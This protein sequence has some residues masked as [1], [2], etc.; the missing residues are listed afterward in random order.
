MNFLSLP[1]ISLGLGALLLGAL[2]CLKSTKPRLAAVAGAT[3]SLAFF[4]L[5]AFDSSNACQT[6]LF[7]PW[8]PCFEAD[9]LDAVPMAFFAALTLAVLILAPKRDAWGRSL[10]GI[11][12]LVAATQTT[13][14]AEN[15]AVLAAGW[16]LTSLP[17]ALRMFGDDRSRKITLGALMAASLALTAGIISLHHTEIAEISHASRLSFGLM[18]LAI[19]L[20]KGLFPIHGWLIHSFEH[21]P[22]LPLAL[23]FNGHLGALLAARSETAALTLAEKDVLVLLSIAAIL[24]ALVTSLRGFAEK[25]PRRLLGLLCLSQSSFILAGVS[26]ASVEGIT[27]ALVHWLVV[28]AASTGLIAIVRVLEVRVSGT[29]APTAYLGLAIKAPRLATFFLVCGLALIGL[30]GTLGYCAE[31]LIFHGALDKHTWIGIALPIATAFNAINLLRIFNI[32]FLG[33]LPKHVID[34]P[35]ALPRERWPLAAMVVFL[36]AGGIFPAKVLQWREIAA[37]Q[38]AAGMGVGKS[39]HEPPQSH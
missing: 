7:D 33:V 5:A 2:F 17:F 28:A 6:K 31:D 32:L 12:L 26:T 29:A 18:I 11:L 13:Y 15:L 8:M 36:I 23:L 22:L 1:Y 14:A 9:A 19:F 37:H 25:K 3:V 20:R 30:P 34:I 35:D 21:G 10:A 39:A 27:G 16:W 24:T 38:I 4:F